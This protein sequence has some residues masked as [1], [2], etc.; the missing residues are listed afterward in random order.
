MRLKVHH[1]IRFIYGAPA[2]FVIQVLRLTPRG[3]ASQFVRRWSIDID[4][5]CRLDKDEDAYGNITHTFTAVGS[6]ERLRIAIAGEVDLTD[7]SGFV[8]GTAERF[9]V[10]FWLRETPGTRAD[11]AVRTFA[12]R[13]ASGLDPLAMAHALSSGVAEAVTVERDDAG[14]PRL[15]AQTLAQGAG[16]AADLAELL[17]AAARC[18]GLPAR[19]VHGYH[20][21]DE[22]T[23]EDASQ[24]PSLNGAHVWAEIAVPGYGWI[25]FDPVHRLCTTNRHVRIAVGLDRRDAS[26]LRSA[27]SGGLEET[28]EELIEV[29][30]GRQMVDG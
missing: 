7:Q 5:E 15:P 21:A 17:V 12:D 30:P 23:E 1:E 14:R 16:S 28:R 9:P 13:G 10:A 19:F 4:A 8:R 20:C 25:G 2:R 11:H 26:P 6:L 3:F 22:T 24:P 29:A 18:A 27:Q